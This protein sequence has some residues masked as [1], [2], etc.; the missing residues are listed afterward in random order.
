M[1]EIHDS[2]PH[3]V[4]FNLTAQDIVYCQLA[5]RRDCGRHIQTAAE[6]SAG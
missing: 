5:N 2:S 4:F 1:H 6:K 3:F